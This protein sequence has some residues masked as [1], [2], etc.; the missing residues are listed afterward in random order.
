[1]STQIVFFSK[2]TYGFQILSMSLNLGGLNGYCSGHSTRI[3][4][5]Y[6]SYGLSRGPEN[7]NV[8]D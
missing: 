4:N 6:P 5:Q 8:A 7:A 1:M 3:L 2:S